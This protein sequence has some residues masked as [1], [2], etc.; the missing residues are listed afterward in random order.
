MAFLHV[1]LGTFVKLFTSIIYSVKLTWLDDVK[2]Y[3]NQVE[4]YR[5]KSLAWFRI[6]HRELHDI[7]DDIA[8]LRI[9]LQ[10]E[11]R[12]YWVLIV[13]QLKNDLD[14][15]YSSSILSLKNESWPLIDP[16]TYFGEVLKTYF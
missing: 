10:F 15:I 3:V 2:F 13:P 7:E 12:P 1:F 9:P 5:T 8:C 6:F 16:I 11:G 4:F 14:E